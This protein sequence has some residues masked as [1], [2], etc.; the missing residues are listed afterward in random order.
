[1]NMGS[2]L[3]L[4]TTQMADLEILRQLYPI[5]LEHCPLFSLSYPVNILGFAARTRSAASVC[6]EQRRLCE[7]LTPGPRSDH[8]ARQRTRTWAERIAGRQRLRVLTSFVLDSLCC[9]WCEQTPAEHRGDR[10]HLFGSRGVQ[11]CSLSKHGIV[12]QSQDGPRHSLQ[13]SFIQVWPLDSHRSTSVT[14]EFVSNAHSQASPKADWI[15]ISR[16]GTPKSV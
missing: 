2:T 8:L 11:P 3:R 13:Q 12:V 5:S 10:C 15:R 16:D 7:A 14:W 1:M 6:T 4:E 9:R